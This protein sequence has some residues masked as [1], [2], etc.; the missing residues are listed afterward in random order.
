MYY[1]AKN[2]VMLFSH[3]ENYWSHVGKGKCM[4]KPVFLL[5]YCLQNLSL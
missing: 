4:E 3:S 1:T 5:Y 2:T